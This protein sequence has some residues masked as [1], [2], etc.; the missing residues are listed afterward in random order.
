MFRYT[1]R[2]ARA[3]SCSQALPAVRMGAAKWG[4]SVIALA[5][6]VLLSLVISACDS[7]S[8][9][10]TGNNTTNGGNG[11]SSFPTT[12][13]A[14]RVPTFSSSEQVAPTVKVLASVDPTL[15]VQFPLVPSGLKALFPN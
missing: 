2:S 1:T 14:L 9:Q 7:S 10:N 3:F 15:I 12:A 13:P 11:Q 8:A 5:L 4:R 6:I